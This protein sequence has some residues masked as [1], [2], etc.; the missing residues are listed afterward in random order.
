MRWGV[1]V[2]WLAAVLAVAGAA[3]SY[4]ARP[5]SEPSA[6]SAHPPLEVGEMRFE[7]L[8]DSPGE[9]AFVILIHNPAPVPRRI[10]GVGEG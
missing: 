7:V 10:I 2:V 9:R 8:T 3:V 4:F 6:R 5:D 1:Q